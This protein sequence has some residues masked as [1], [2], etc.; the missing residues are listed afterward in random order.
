ML[1]S[2]GGDARGTDRPPILFGVGSEPSHLCNRFEK[3]D[4]LQRFPPCTFSAAPNVENGTPEE[5]AAKAA[6]AAEELPSA[7]VAEISSR[8]RDNQRL[9]APAGPAMVES[10]QHLR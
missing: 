6:A 10:L 5:R 4:F 2:C 9:A 3:R 7:T 8:R 1:I